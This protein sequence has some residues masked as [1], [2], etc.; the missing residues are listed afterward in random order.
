LAGELEDGYATTI[1]AP[2]IQRPFLEN[3]DADQKA[4]DILI[5]HGLYYSQDI[6]PDV[7]TLKVFIQKYGLLAAYS[8]SLWE[9][10]LV[11]HVNEGMV[12]AIMSE[13]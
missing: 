12:K 3:F 1:M 11:N 8:K 9:E 5:A 2:Y 13:L 7:E 4:E 6:H 10:F